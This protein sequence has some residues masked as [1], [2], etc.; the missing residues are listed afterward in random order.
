MLKRL[1][2][3]YVSKMKK[4]AHSYQALAVAQQCLQWDSS[5]NEAAE[6]AW[7]TDC[8]LKFPGSLEWEWFSL[9]PVSSCWECPEAVPW[10]W[11]AFQH[12]L[13]SFT[14]HNPGTDMLQEFIQNGHQTELLRGV[15]ESLHLRLWSSSSMWT[16]RW[17]S[18]LPLT[19]KI[20]SNFI[21][22]I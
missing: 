21:R 17:C 3:N 13:I 15:A 19:F 16:L 2:I 1:E 20:H 5:R 11:L 7:H 14:S 12:Q 10:N 4:H 8:G 22:L 18:K 6:E 9:S